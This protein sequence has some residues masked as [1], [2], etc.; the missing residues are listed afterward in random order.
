MAG[1]AAIAACADTTRGESNMWEDCVLV[2]IHV[3]SISDKV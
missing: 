1:T 3:W 2:H